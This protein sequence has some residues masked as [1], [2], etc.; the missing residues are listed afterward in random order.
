MSIPLEHRELMSKSD[1]HSLASEQTQDHRDSDRRI[2]ESPRR[3]ESIFL[4]CSA[5]IKIAEGFSLL[6][7]LIS[8][9]VKGRTEPGVQ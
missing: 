8:F 5:N 7:T 2:R 4:K 9:H 6:F 3:K 1:H